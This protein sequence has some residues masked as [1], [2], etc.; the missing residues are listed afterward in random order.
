MQVHKEHIDFCQDDGNVRAKEE[1]YQHR[2]DLYFVETVARTYTEQEVKEDLL[3]SF[4]LDSDATKGWIGDIKRNGKD[5]WLVWQR[6]L[7]SRS[8][9]VEQDIG[10]MAEYLET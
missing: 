5:N 6:Q 8:Y 3:A 9:S 2:Q 7:Q 10:R 1:T 4:V